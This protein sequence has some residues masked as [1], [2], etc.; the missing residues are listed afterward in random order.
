MT[1]SRA[2]T[3]DLVAIPNLSVQ[4]LILFFRGVIMLKFVVSG[5][6]NERK[7]SAVIE[8]KD[9]QQAMAVAVRRGIKVTGVQPFNVRQK[10]EEG[11]E[12][13]PEVPASGGARALTYVPA[14]G[15]VVFLAAGAIGN[16]VALVLGTLLFTGAYFMCSTRGMKDLWLWYS[17]TAIV[18]GALSIAGL[19]GHL[20]MKAEINSYVNEVGGFLFGVATFCGM[21]GSV[22][23]GF[24]ERSFIHPDSSPIWFLV[25]FA[26]IGVLLHLALKK[27]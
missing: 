27:V 7:T 12:S 24:D 15:G 19:L 16:P 13:L 4:C 21:F 8:A 20:A 26:S 9:A 22:T 14:V 1:R 6:Q 5:I 18:V 3:A 17:R 11:A 23:L 2:P 25:R 10:A